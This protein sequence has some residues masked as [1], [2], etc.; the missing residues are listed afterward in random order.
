MRGLYAL[1]SL[2]RLLVV[3]LLLAAALSIPGILS[4]EDNH[5]PPPAP[6]NDI[7]PPKPPATPTPTPTS[8]PTPRVAFEIVSYHTVPQQL[9]AREPFK[10]YLEIRNVGNVPANGWSI[11]NVNCESAKIIS[12]FACSV[13]ISNLEIGQSAS[14][15]LD[16]RSFEMKKAEGQESLELEYVKPLESE[17]PL[18]TPNKIT[19]TFLFLPSRTI[20]DTQPTLERPL[21]RPNINVQ[22]TWVAKAR[23]TVDELLTP[24][25]LIIHSIPIS[26]SVPGGPEFEL[27]VE[28]QNYGSVEASNIFIDFCANHPY[29]NPVGSTCVKYVP[30]N[31]PPG[32]NAIASQTLAY[33][34]DQKLSTIDFSRGVSVTLTIS[35]Q[36]WYVEQWVQTEV[37]RTIY[38]YPQEFPAGTPVPAPQTPS[39][40]V[41]TPALNVRQGPGTNYA[42]IDVAHQGEVFAITGK[43][44][45]GKEDWWQIDYRG[46]TA[47]VSAYWVQADRGEQVPVATAIPPTPPPVPPGPVGMHQDSAPAPAIGREGLPA[48]GPTPQFV[49]HSEA[50]TAPVRLSALPAAGQDSV[51][52]AAAMGQA[53]PLVVL[54]RYASIPER[55][56]GNQ[57]FRLEFVL[58][59]AGQSSA[60]QTVLL[61]TD[62]PVVPLGAG[63]TRWLGDLAPGAMIAVAGEFLLRPGREA[64]VMQMR[65]DLRYDDER[66][67][68]YLRAEEIALLADAPGQIA[69]AAPA[70]PSGPRPLWLRFVAGLLGLGA[71]R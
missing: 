18:P 57:P 63:N 34:T 1:S 51:S 28:I 70:S 61:L 9:R 22:R 64:P 37:T 5:P 36:F 68:S 62:D 32:G 38:L 49:I 19:F 67:E 45:N 33:K 23:S 69:E 11:K 43:H 7:Q 12:E 30:A 52:A 47:W 35:S 25:P 4:G 42:V 29:F 41:Q 71:G 13:P 54:E 66:G 20:T 3:A 40:T 50:Q 44:W 8:A 60:R 27:A 46:R 31:L 56:S 15:V 6:E 24:V 21:A 48:A 59:N 58:R 10:L 65:L 14:I 39:L 16:L 2:F 53:A 26:P 55:I 17:L